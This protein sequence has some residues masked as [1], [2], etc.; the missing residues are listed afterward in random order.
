M[1]EKAEAIISEGTTNIPV[2]PQDLP[3]KI[4]D[5][6]HSGSMT[7]MSFNSEELDGIDITGNHLFIHMDT[8]VATN[9]MPSK[10]GS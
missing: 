5:G 4:K 8:N 7:G 6:I 2:R 10:S 1:I 3:V 9:E